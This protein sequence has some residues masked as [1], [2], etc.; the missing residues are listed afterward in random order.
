MKDKLVSWFR[1]LDFHKQCAVVGV[2]IFPPLI[3]YVLAYSFFLLLA[4]INPH[5][6]GEGIAKFYLFLSPVVAVSCWLHILGVT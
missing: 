2:L 6:L 3:L 5:P 4:K 1:T